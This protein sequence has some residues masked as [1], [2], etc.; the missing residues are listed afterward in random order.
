MMING[1]LLSEL[2]EKDESDK[3]PVQ[4]NNAIKLIH[5]TEI[6]LNYTGLD[7]SSE[8]QVDNFIVKYLNSENEFDSSE[9][10]KNNIQ[11]EIKYSGITARTSKKF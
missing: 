5:N 11:A 7:E 8:I 6:I 1:Y 9:K 10:F 4:F 2:L 3:M